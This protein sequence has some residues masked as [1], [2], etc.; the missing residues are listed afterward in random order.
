MNVSASDTASDTVSDAGGAQLA[1]RHLVSAPTATTIRRAAFGLVVALLVA[2]GVLALLGHIGGFHD[3]RERLA[4]ADEKW[5]V[6]CFVAQLVV[7]AGYALSYQAA[8]EFEGGPRVP[9]PLSY[10]VVITTFTATQVVTAGG[11]AGVAL[12]YWS[13]HRVGFRAREGAVR[14]IGLNTLVYLVFGAIGWFGAL[15]CLVFAKA[16]L[17]MTVPWVIAYP[18]ILMLAGWFT[19]PGRVE[20]WTS[21][22]GGR[23]RRSLGVGIS[24]AYF[25]LR[26]TRSGPLP[27]G[28][29]GAAMYWIA[30]IVSLAGGLLV[31]GIHPGIA[32]LVLAYATGYLAQLIPIPFLGTGGVDAS[33]AAC[34]SLVGLPLNAALLGV[35]AHRL[36][37][38]WLPII[39]GVVLT[40]TLPATGRALDKVVPLD[41]KARP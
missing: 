9:Y 16:P 21:E 6:V 14:A 33:T 22:E 26:Y 38:F 20:R 23:L 36:F 35:L 32:A 40:A 13:M 7:F 27:I 17:G 10:R 12:T 8:I 15:V 25:V 19:A 41:P 39:P 31:F 37:A 34:L 28:V 2:A 29:V 30:D 5:L 1:D 11:A 18:L 24:A 3:L 4:S